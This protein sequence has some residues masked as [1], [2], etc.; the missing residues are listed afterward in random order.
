MANEVI[1][2]LRNMFQQGGGNFTR[3]ST[4]KSSPINYPIGTKFSTV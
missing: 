2:L 3:N 4:D 1:S